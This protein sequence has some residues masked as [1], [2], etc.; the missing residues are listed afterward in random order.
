M[1]APD[2]KAIALAIPAPSGSDAGGDD[3]SDGESAAGDILDAIEAKDA[4]ALNAALKSW[5]ALSDVDEPAEG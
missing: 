5:L 2:P 3:M 4:K 1:A